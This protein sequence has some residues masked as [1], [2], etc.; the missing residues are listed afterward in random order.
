MELVCELSR[1]TLDHS[2]KRG[3]VLHSS[4]ADQFEPLL[5][6]MVLVDHRTYIGIF[7]AILMVAVIVSTDQ[8]ESYCIKRV[9]MRFIDSI[10]NMFQLIVGQGKFKLKRKIMQI[11][12][13]TLTVGLFVII[14][15]VL[16]NLLQTEKVAQR[17]PDQLNTIDD[18][19][20]DEFKGIEPTMVLNS[21]TYVLSKFVLNG[22]KQAE[23]FKQ[24]QKNDSNLISVTST[25]VNMI[26]LMYDALEKKDRYV[27]LEEVLWRQ[28]RPLVCR[29]DPNMVT[30]SHTG[31][32][33]LFDGL[34][35]VL[36]RKDIDHRL[37][38]YVEYRL[39]NK[40]EL[41]LSAS[42]YY[43]IFEGI[44]KLT[45]QW[46]KGKTNSTKCLSDMKDA[47]NDSKIQF[48]LEHSRLFI[49][50]LVIVMILSTAVYFMEFLMK[51]IWK[52]TSNSIHCV[53]RMY[54]RIATS[55]GNAATLLGSSLPK[56]KLRVR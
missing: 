56:I 35:V 44:A 6:T 5:D 36:Y 43:G 9:C 54:S 18:I 15:G 40:F 12:F 42:E 4:K 47:D 23:I 48:K 26:A 10:W 1:P 37:K 24:L 13:L 50:L 17:S 25:K 8:L 41:G 29:C 45:G 30:V 11:L 7:A 28:L 27:L 39:K 46:D 49:R 19:V 51:R 2:A 32:E 52:S 31:S 3:F 34:L 38:K 16:L 21:N 53:A 22:S 33:I 55:L 20:G 14:S